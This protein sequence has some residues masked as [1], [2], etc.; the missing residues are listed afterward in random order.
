M[1]TYYAPYTGKDDVY[2]AYFPSIAFGSS[3]AFYYGN[4]NTTSNS[5]GPDTTNYSSGTGSVKNEKININGTWK[6][7]YYHKLNIDGT[8]KTLS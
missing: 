8:W 3:G 4:S 7:V 6:A 1:K 2:N 5:T